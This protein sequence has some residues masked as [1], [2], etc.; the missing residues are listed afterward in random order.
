MHRVQTI[1]QHIEILFH[2]DAAGEASVQSR[3]ILELGWFDK[4]DLPEGLP[5]SQK[6][7]IKQLLG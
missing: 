5:R 1:R 4:D 7:V 6:Y 3:E 2:A